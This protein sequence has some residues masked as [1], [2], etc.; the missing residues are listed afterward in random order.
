MLNNT[1]VLAYYFQHGNISPRLRDVG[2][3]PLSNMV[4][5]CDHCKRTW[6]THKT[7]WK[8]HEKPPNLMKEGEGRVFQTS[9]SDLLQV[10]F[11]PLRNN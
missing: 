10:C 11:H 9:T 5:W 2:K 8:L 3:P 1:T 4:P 7:C 6:L